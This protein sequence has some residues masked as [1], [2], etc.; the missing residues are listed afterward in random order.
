MSD[1]VKVSSKGQITLPAGLR[2][3]LKIKPGTRLRLIETEKDFRVIVAPQ[4]IANL[5]GAVG[6]DGPQ[7]FKKAREVAM[8]DRVSARRTRP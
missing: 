5:L 1:I 8:E 3:R 2:K 4:G 7:D 6:V